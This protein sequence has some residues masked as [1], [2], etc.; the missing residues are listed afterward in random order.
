[1]EINQMPI[2]QQILN[3]AREKIF[4]ITNANVKIHVEEI[5]D[6]T[7]SFLLEE[8]SVIVSVTFNVSWQEIKGKKRTTSNNA[9]DARHT[10]MYV[11]HKILGYSCIRVGKFIGNRE[12]STVLYACKKIKDWYK[13]GD[14][15]IKT[16]DLIIKRIP[17]EN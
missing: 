7:K 13:V 10:F 6:D 8:L 4:S 2:V 3:D 15:I 14:P 11:A 17:R 12:Y 5:N 16:I 9:V 1:M